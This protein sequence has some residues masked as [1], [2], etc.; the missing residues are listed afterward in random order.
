M[1]K[2]TTAQARKSGRRGEA[3]PQAQRRGRQRHVLASGLAAFG[4]VAVVVGVWWL[5]AGGLSPGVPVLYRFQT[6]DYHALV[7]DPSDPETVYFG[8]HGGLL[9]SRDGGRT[10]QASALTGVDAMQIAVP[11]ADPRRIYVSGHN[12]F[13]LSGDG[14]NTWAVPAPALPGLDIHGFAV[15][16]SDPDWVY[17][18][19]YSSF[20]LYLSRDGGVTWETRS[21]PPGMNQ[22]MLPLAVAADDPANVYAGVGSRVWQSLDAGGSWQPLGSGLEGTVSALAAP[23]GGRTLLYAGTDRGLWRLGDSGAWERLPIEPGEAVLAVAAVPLAGGADRIVLVD[24]RGNFYRTDD[25]GQTW[26]SR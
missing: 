23:A 8:H 3:R 19:E 20:G 24:A 16:P 18:F 17:A 26:V 25:G 6:E 13:V 12:V 9:V 11:A 4:L 7:V 10:W 15:A 21:L 14:G 22:G 2:R 5:I 1:T